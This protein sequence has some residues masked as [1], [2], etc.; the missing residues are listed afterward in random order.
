MIR[1]LHFTV[2]RRFK[3]M[4]LSLLFLTFAMH[5]A[6]DVFS[7]S[8]TVSCSCPPE[9]PPRARTHGVRKMPIVRSLQDFSGSNGSSLDGSQMLKTSELR[10]VQKQR[11]SYHG[12]KLASLFKHPLYNSLMPDITEEDKLFKVNAMERFT[13][14]SSES[15]EW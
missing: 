7:L 8:T 3:L 11:R 1:R 4:V 12:S 13:L 6:L 5:F 9:N 15:E 14:K 10:N 2:Q